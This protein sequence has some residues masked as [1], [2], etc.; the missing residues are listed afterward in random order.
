[1]LRQL[2]HIIKVGIY[3]LI[4]H[5]KTKYTF[6]QRYMTA[7]DNH[8]VTSRDI[9][10]GVGRKKSRPLSEMEPDSPNVQAFV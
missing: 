1:V 8:L 6:F 10:D 9:L 2:V 4:I 5:H 7:S 3:L